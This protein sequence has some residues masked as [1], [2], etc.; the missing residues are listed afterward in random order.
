MNGELIIE[1]YLTEN[2]FEDLKDYEGLYKINR[3]GEVWSCHYKKL[4]IPQDTED[5]YLW[6]KLTR[7]DGRHKGRIHRL[8][9]IQYLENPNNL[10]EVDHIDRQRQ[11][12]EL[13][14]LRWVDKITQNNNRSNCLTEEQK[15]ERVVEIREYKRVKAEE[16]RRAKGVQPKRVFETEEERKEAERECKKESARKCRAERTPEQREEDNR[17]K[18]E[19]RAKK[20]ASMSPEELEAFRNREKERT[21]RNQS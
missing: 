8:L 4:M 21:K 1:T 7:S 20:L 14:N 10:P 11:N 5:E 2:G 12:N 15:E 13:S 19:A 3:K 9:A 17:K 16:Y 18:R 6:V